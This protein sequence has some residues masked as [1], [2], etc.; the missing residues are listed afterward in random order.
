MEYILLAIILV[1]IICGY[2]TASYFDLKTIRKKEKE[3]SQYQDENLNLTI[4]KEAVRFDLSVEIRKSGK[5][6]ELIE[7]FY[8]ELSEIEDKDL[9][10]KIKELVEDFKG[11]N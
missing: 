11:I 10:D 2:T 7:K 5:K 4:E 1:S 8:N 9:R 6:D 3:I